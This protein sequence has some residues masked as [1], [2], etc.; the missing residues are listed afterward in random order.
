MPPKPPLARVMTKNIAT[1]P[2]MLCLVS[3]TRLNNKPATAEALSHG[4][5]FDPSDDRQRLF[6][7]NKPKANFSR[8]AAKAGFISSLQ[9]RELSAIPALVLPVILILKENNACVLTAID[10]EKGV[11]EIIVP[12]VDEEA[13][14]IDLSKLAD[15]YQ[16]YAFFL[17]RR[18]EGF[19]QDKLVNGGDS[20][21]HWFFGTLQRF[22]ATY[23]RVL[24]ATLLVNIF[25]VAGPLFTMNVYDRVIPHHAVDTLWVLASGVFIIYLFDLLLKFLRT[26]F[27]E[28]VAKKTDIILSSKLFEQAMNLKMAHKPRS[29]GSF[30]SNIKDFDGIR[31]FFASSA[32]TAFIELPFSI[33]FLMVIY[34]ISGTMALVPLAVI[35][36]VLGISLVLKGPLERIVESTQEAAARRNGIL[37][38]ALANLATIKAFNANS[39]AQWHWE[40]SS[41]DIADKSLH[42]R[43]LLSYLA[44][45]SSFLSQLGTVAIVVLGVYQIRAGELTMGGLIA[46]IMLSSRAIAPMSQVVSLIANFEQMKAGLHSLNELMAK[47]VERPENKRFLRRPQFQG[48]IELKGVSFCYPDDQRKALSNVGFH[49]QPGERLGII[50]SVGSGKST[51]SNLLLDFYEPS[52]GSLFIDGIDIKQIDPADLRHSIAYVPQDVVLFSGTVRENITLKFPHADDQAILTAAEV[53]KVNSFTDRHPLGLDLQVGERGLNLSGGQRQSVA[54]ARAFLEESPIVL[55]DEPTNSM[56]FNT[57]LKVIDNLREATKGKTTIIITHKPAILDIVDRII[58]LEGGN[59]VMDGPRTEILAKLGGKRP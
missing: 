11:A 24:L 15:Q 46:V 10:Q 33:I 41:G 50:G 1:D 51:I 54:V 17:K 26:N 5:P 37:E 4:L 14:E 40:E 16:G 9:E 59:L 28:S 39:S 52:E 42:S 30:S 18:Y 57:E 27:L 19:G 13:M 25:V 44:M 29:V 47:E 34:S 2:L 6:S 45:A 7:I 8:A 38:E 55:L 53:G 36:L 20:D 43:V 22:R 31:S 12:S 3:L 32:I 21:G 58:V 48:E 35:G 49:L 56:D 23:G